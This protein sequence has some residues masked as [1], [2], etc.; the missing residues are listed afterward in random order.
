MELV[1]HASSVAERLS[2]FSSKGLFE[3]T[4][5]PPRR[6]FPFYLFFR[7]S[8][9]MDKRGI[10][11]RNMSVAHTLNG[12]PYED[13]ER[14]RSGTHSHNSDVEKLA[15]MGKKQLLK[16]SFYSQQLQGILLLV[17]AYV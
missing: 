15:R 14:M 1:P 8:P 7:F 4:Y 3:R 12:A 5:F 16:V 2:F 11:L 10:E 17:L 6:Y 9:T 13:V